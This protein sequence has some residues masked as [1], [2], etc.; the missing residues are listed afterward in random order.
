MGG[1]A[2]GGEE[3]CGRALRTQAALRFRPA[4]RWR[5]PLG[6]EAQLRGG[7]GQGLEGVRAGMVRLGHAGEAGEGTL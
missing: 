2:G 3:V 4:D 1:G 5:G 7:C 6:R